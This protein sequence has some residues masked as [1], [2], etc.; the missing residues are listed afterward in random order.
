MLHIGRIERL[1]RMLE[2]TPKQLEAV[3]RDCSGCYE[4]LILLDPAKPHKRREVLNVRGAIRKFQERLYRKILAPKLTPSP[5]SHGCVRHKSIKSNATVHLESQFVMKGDISDFYP[6][7]HYKRIYRLFTKELKC[8]P[9]VARACT[10]LCSYRH[11]LALGLVTSP[12]LANQV[13]APVDRRVGAI[14]ATAG[15]QYSR[16]VDDITI[17][18][19]FDLEPSGFRASIEN[20][21][22]EHGFNAHPD[23]WVFG[24]VNDDIAITGICIRN[25]HLDLSLE[26]LASVSEQIAM[27]RRLAAGE[28]VDGSYVTRSQLLGRIAFIV[29]ISPGRGLAMRREVKAID[30]D[31]AIENAERFGLVIARKRLISKSLLRNP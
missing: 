10:K 21:L 6:S 30:W 18:G 23:K 12:I 31:A 3:L 19:P 16:F 20:I 11:H 1:A 9:D 25:R 4:E 29:W 28:R 15:L 26:Y 7:V 8:S 13:L 2:T 17:S 27:I 14:C 22:A 24:D 5:Y